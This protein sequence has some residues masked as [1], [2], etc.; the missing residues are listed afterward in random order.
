MDASLLSPFLISSALWWRAKGCREKLWLTFRFSLDREEITEEV[1]RKSSGPESWGGGL[2]YLDRI[3][4][5]GL[6]LLFRG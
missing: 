1:G 5:T 2:H 4:Y 6:C 3:V